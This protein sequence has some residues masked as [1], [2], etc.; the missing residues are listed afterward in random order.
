MFDVV[1][2]PVREQCAQFNQLLDTQRHMPPG[3]VQLEG[4]ITDHGI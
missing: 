3:T 1:Q 2:C 4:Q